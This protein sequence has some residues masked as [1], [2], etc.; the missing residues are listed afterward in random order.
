MY[1]SNTLLQ[2]MQ[3]RF[4]RFMCYPKKGSTRQHLQTI[5]QVAEQQHV[6]AERRERRA[7]AA[8]SPMP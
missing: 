4:A 7:S 1:I 3:F 5:S 2:T 6:A 8:T